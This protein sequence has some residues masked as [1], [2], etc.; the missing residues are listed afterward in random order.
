M[1][2]EK[3]F[4]NPFGALKIPG[5]PEKAAAPAPAKKKQ[6]QVSVDEE[7]A[8]FLSAMNAFDEVKPV[9]APAA[10]AVVEAHA[11]KVAAEDLEALVE[12]A[13]MVAS[14]PELDVLRDGDSVLG[15]AKGFDAALLERLQAGA[16]AVT[17]Q[18]D[19]SA[20][21]GD[22]VRAMLDRFFAEARTKRM[23]C[24]RVIAPETAS[25]VAALTAPKLAKRVLAFAAGAGR[26]DVLL[27]S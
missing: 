14:D 15:H 21:S 9:R 6:E 7:S 17:A 12:L 2:K 26:V 4:N 11:E 19:V 27:R 23:R 20:A 5:K 22:A 16:L 3:P 1:A 13:E 10:P 24:V 25:V 8:L 18:L